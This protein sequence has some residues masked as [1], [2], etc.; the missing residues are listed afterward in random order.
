MS[1]VIT[2]PKEFLKRGELVIIPRSEYEAFLDW[3]K[4]VKTYK[5]TDSEKRALKE[6]RKDFSQGRYITLNELKDEL[7]GSR[8]S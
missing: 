8:S 4:Y 5:P 6:A 3:Q 1:E 2:I 7:A